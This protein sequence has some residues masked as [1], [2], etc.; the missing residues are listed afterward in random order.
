MEK[1]FKN[2]EILSKNFLGKLFCIMRLTLFILTTSAL[3]LFASGSYSQSARVSLDLKSVTVKQAL[4]AIENSS[5]FFFIY[6][7]ELINVE[8]KID[9]TVRN[10]KISDILSEVFDGAGVEVSVIDRKIVLAPTF[11]GEQQNG[12][13]IAGKVTDSAGVPIPGASVVVKGTTIGVITDN[14]GNYS[15]SNIPEKATLQFSFV[16]TKSQEVVVGGKTTL[17]ITLIEETIGIDE[18]VAIGYGTSKK[19]DLTGAT[20][21]ISAI[22]LEKIPITT[23]GQGLQGRSAG[24]QVTS[25]DGSP[26]SSVSVK[27]RGTGTFGDNSPLYVVDGYPISGDLSQIN[28]NDIATMDILK[29]ASAT[30]IYGNR[31]SNGVVIITT[32]R[33]KNQDLQVSVEAQTSVQSKPGSYAVMNAAQFALAAQAVNK[34]EGYPIEP[35]WNNPGSLRNIDWQNALYRTGLTQNYNVSL[36]GGNEKVQ[37]SFSVGYMDQK[38]IVLFSDFKRFNSSMALDYMPAKWLKI[39]SNMKYTRSERIV[40]FGSGMW[41]IGYLTRA[42]PTMT[43]NPVTDQIK[44]ANGNYGYY[45][46]TAKATYACSNIYAD[47]EDQDVKNPTNNFMSTCALE[48]S[49][50]KGFKFKSNVGGNIINNSGYNFTKSSD[51]TNPPVVATYTQQANDT[52]E[53]LW[54]NTLAYNRIFGIHSIDFVGGISSQENTYRMMSTTGTGQLSNELRNV[55]S[56]TTIIPTGYQQTWSLASQFGRL[57][58]KMADKYI[59]TGTVRHDGSSRFGPGKKWGVFPSLAAAWNISDESFMKGF[60]FLNSLKIRGSWGKAGNQNI[61]LFQYQSNYTTGTS[62]ADNRGYV[63]GTTKAYQ[64]GI[65]LNS[66]PN[67]NLTWESSDQT[68]IG[69]DAS[70]LHKHFT[71]TADYYNRE[72]SDFLLNVPVPAQTGFTTATRN[73]GSIRNRGVELFLE[74]RES[75]KKFKWSVSGNLTTVNNKI[76]SFTD[77]VTSI[78]NPT[79]ALGFLA[80][81]SNTWS[82]YSQSTVGGNIGAFYGFK[83]DGIYQAKSEIDAMNAVTKAKY[84]ANAFY[85]LSATSPGDRKFIDTNNDGRITDADRVVIGSPIP[86]MFGGLNF[87]GAFKQFDFSVFVYFCYGNDLFNYQRRNLETFDRASGAALQNMGLDY[88][89]NYWTADRHSNTYTR[90]LAYDTVGNNRPSDAYVEDGSYIRLKNLQI[91]YTL[92]SAISDRIHCAKIRFFLSGQNLFTITKYTGLDPEVGDQG[93]VTGSG[94]DVGSFPSSKAYTLGLNIGF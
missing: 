63:F 66:L 71:L 78:S 94:I 84:G 3:S 31:A 36:R 15:L 53:W 20:S 50:L 16:G 18:V 13:K 14:N 60:K 87:D 42:I 93:G 65:A 30:A 1:N 7:N 49:F 69:F 24:V 85:Q 83:T 12:K 61:G 11:M 68:N 80:Y 64:N 55:G 82:V 25:N 40:R 23:L 54:E 75:E 38:G 6:N 19:R 4:D 48:I 21:S 89:N 62:L 47:T 74:Y 57:S 9:L 44:D 73:V 81:G 41:Q 34:S 45:S 72:S 76:L 37:S 17:N 92:P 29:D 8:R 58:Y 39:S 86:K 28:T 77:G 91:G 32:K 10:K 90:L 46:K 22:Q 59:F 2:R 26:G 67:P 43:G 79:N 33:G 56:L 27:I 52:Y 35:E 51:R 70:F 5:E 88:Y